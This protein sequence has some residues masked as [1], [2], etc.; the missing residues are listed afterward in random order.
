[1]DGAEAQRPDQCARDALAPCRSQGPRGCCLIRPAGQQQQDIRICQAP[2]REGDRSALEAESSHSGIVDGDDERPVVAQQLERAPD[3][4]P[5][6][7]RVHGHVFGVTDEEGDLECTLPG[8]CRRR[9]HLV[10]KRQMEQ[11]RRG[12]RSAGAL[13]LEPAG[14][15]TPA[16][17][18]RRPR[19]RREAERR[20]ADSGVAFEHERSR[21]LDRAF[22]EPAHEQ[23]LLIPADNF[24]GHGCPDRDTKHVHNREREQPRRWRAKACRAKLGVLTFPA[25]DRR[26]S[27]DRVPSYLVEENVSRSRPRRRARRT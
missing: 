16:D 18:L 21:T 22:E 23:E 7:P 8:R 2:Q 25:C 14:S 9:Q 26:R 11:F 6:S 4:E 20:L 10:Q 5:D 1:M 12:R 13:S 15:R 24:H 3:R 19:P 27:V 17:P